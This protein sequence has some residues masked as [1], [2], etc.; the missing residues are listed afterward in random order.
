MSSP[1]TATC[2]KTEILTEE[3]HHMILEAIRDS[4]GMSAR[5]N[6]E[7]IRDSIL[8]KNVMQFGGCD[9]EAV[10]ITDVDR[11]AVVLAQAVDVLIYKG[12]GGVSRP[13]REHIR[14]RLTVFGRQIKIHTSILRTRR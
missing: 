12:K 8:V 6:F 2:L 9:A 1:S 11:N 14:L 5:I 10:L 4:A 7:L 13:L 3:L